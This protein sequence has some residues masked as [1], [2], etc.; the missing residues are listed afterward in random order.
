MMP[1]ARNAVRIALIFAETSVKLALIVAW[2]RGRSDVDKRVVG[3][4]S[5]CRHRGDGG[6]AGPRQLVFVELPR[7][8]R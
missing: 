6:V 7:H 8:V 4:A 3:G 2:G 1:T 5:N